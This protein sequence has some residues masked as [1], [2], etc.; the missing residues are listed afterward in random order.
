MFFHQFPPLS[1]VIGFGGFQP[2]NN[3]GDR[4]T[5]VVAGASDPG[6]ILVSGVNDTCSQFV[7]RSN[8]LSPTGSFLLAFVTVIVDTGD[9]TD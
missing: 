3:I 4:R 7:S 8:S 6:K 9:H 5:F 1:L 2:K